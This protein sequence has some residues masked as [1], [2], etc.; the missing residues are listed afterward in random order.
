ME[1]SGGKRITASI[2]ATE[3]DDHA[4]TFVWPL[5][6]AP[7][8]LPTPVS[9]WFSALSNS[10]DDDDENE[11]V[12]ALAQLTS[13]IRVGPKLSQSQRR[14]GLNM[15]HIKSLAQQIKNG[16]L[17]LPDVELESNDEYKCL[18]ALVDSGA[19]VNC[20]SRDQF[21]NAERIQAPEVQLTTAGG[22]LLPNRGAMKITTVSKEGVSRERVFYDAPVDMP[23]ISIAEVSQEGPRGSNAQLR[24]HDGFIQDNATHEKQHFVKRKGVYFMKIFIKR[25][26]NDVGFHRPGP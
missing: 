19:G 8:P 21:P 16:D 10:D 11:M 15:T 4:E 9:N 2:V 22:D 23:I 12:K 24:K 26:V 6:R 18:W 20:S 7:P 14:K 13:N 1:K 3:P 25:G 5:M 17:N